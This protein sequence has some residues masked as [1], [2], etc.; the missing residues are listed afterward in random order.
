MHGA[1]GQRGDTEA[2]QPALHPRPNLPPG[3]APQAQ[4]GRNVIRDRAVEQQRFLKDG[5]QAA[6]VGQLV[7]AA[8]RRAGVEQL[9][10]GRLLQP[11]QHAQQRALAGA[12]RPDD[13]QHH[14]AAIQLQ[15]RHV[16]DHVPGVLGADAAQR[17]VTLQ[18]RATSGLR[19]SG[20]LRT[21]ERRWRHHRHSF[22][23]TARRSWWSSGY[24]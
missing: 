5:G 8:Q 9:T 10:G 21:G 16:E 2:V 24:G 4:A 7:G 19:R 6:A 11:P 14:L 18:A 15:G 17:Q 20:V 13:D 22:S 3:H 1:P 12:V 23:A